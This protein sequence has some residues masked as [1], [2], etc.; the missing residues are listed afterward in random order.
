MLI[1]AGIAFAEM[2]PWYYTE[3]DWFSQEAAEEA[4]IPGGLTE[5]EMEVYRAGFANG[6][7]DALHPAYIEGLFVLNKKTK[8]FHLSNCMTTLMIETRHREHSDLTAEELMLQGYKPCGQC[9]PER[10]MD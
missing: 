6:H 4:K 9:N 2:N 1:I 7:Y 3:L 8:K 10:S 5:R